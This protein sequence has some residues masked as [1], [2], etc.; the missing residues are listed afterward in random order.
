M[1]LK[2][3]VAVSFVLALSLLLSIALA[4]CGDNTATPAPTATPVPAAADI[5]GVSL[6]GISGL[7]EI[8]VDVAALGDSLKQIP[9]AAL[10]I[11]VCDDTADKVSSTFDAA[12]I[13]AGFV[14]ALP[15]ETKP[16]KQ[17]DAIGGLYAKGDTSDILFV[18]APVTDD[19][20]ALATQM[21][22]PGLNADGLKKLVDQMKGKKTMLVA[23]TTPGVMSAMLK[24]F[25]DMGATPTP[26]K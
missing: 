8:T 25:A 4:A 19:P 24:G 26:T 17:G 7:K 6:G 14:F 15:G 18:V 13:K 9:G 3:K 1:L 10:K 16:T 5:S 11:Y 23:L 20:S 12:A 21:N 2:K 22:I